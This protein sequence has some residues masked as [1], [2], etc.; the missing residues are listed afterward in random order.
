MYDTPLWDSLVE[1]LLAIDRVLQDED[2]RRKKGLV[3]FSDGQD[4]E[5]WYTLEDVIGLTKEIKMPV[6]VVALG[7]SSD[8]M[9]TH[10]SQAI[11][12]LRT[13]A[14]ESRG[15]Y[16][17][18]SDPS[19]LPHVADMV[20]KSFCGGYTELSLRFT[21]PSESGEMVEGDIVMLDAISAPYIF[22]APE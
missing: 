18:V 4:T 13:L 11:E 19:E 1:T 10:S 15:Y 6:H 2:S 3:V 7:H 22:R 9:E 12:D 21:E 20:A 16:A 14:Q 5:S 8:L 17:S